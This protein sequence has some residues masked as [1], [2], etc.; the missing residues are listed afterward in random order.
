[1]NLFSNFKKTLVVIPTV[2]IFQSLVLIS[3][4][5]PYLLVSEQFLGYVMGSITYP[6]SKFFVF[7]LENLIYI[8]LFEILFGHYIYNELR[9]SG[10]Y[11]F[12]RISNKSK[13]FLEKTLHLGV[14]SLIYVS[15]YLF[16]MLF[17]SIY[18][19]GNFPD[20]NVF[21][22]FIQILVKLTTICFIGTLVINV[23]SFYNGTVVSFLIV[24]AIQVL[25][26]FL[27]MN[28]GN[29]DIVKW[30]PLSSLTISSQYKTFNFFEA[31]YNVFLISGCLLFS[32][33]QVK[34]IDLS[35]VKHN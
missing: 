13:W 35:L 30:F 6:D 26:V 4:K 11:V 22:I 5:R 34:K 21:P 23:L 1:M 27:I 29:P 8:F 32:F 7:A 18:S 3:D 25:E 16:I 20:E 15:L 12:S 14:Y 24:Y 31:Y 17:L 10:T 2:L 28:F 33:L 19:T 9:Y